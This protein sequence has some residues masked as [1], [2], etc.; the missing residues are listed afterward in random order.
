MSTNLGLPYVEAHNY[1]QCGANS[2]QI[3]NQ[4]TGFAPP[5][6]PNLSLYCLWADGPDAD[7]QTLMRASTNQAL[8]DQM[9]NASVLNNSNALNRL[10]AKGAREILVE[11]GTEWPANAPWT[12][13]LMGTNSVAVSN[14]NNYV[15]RADQA[16]IGVMN[17]YGRARPDLR[18]QSLDV[19]ARV[20]EIMADPAPYGFTETSLDALYDPSLRNKSFTGPGA[21]YMFWGWHPTTKLHRLIAAWHE[22]MLTNS[23]LETV[24]AHVASGSP[25]VQ[26]DH[27]RVGRDYALQ[28]ST[29]LRAWS[30]VQS[31][32]ASAGTNQWAGSFDN[33]GTQFYRLKWQP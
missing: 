4:V 31:F 17:A 25:V 13:G 15:T 20:I 3:L 1:A 6:K 21:D 30:D 16:F 11:I 22:E 19:M 7:I 5:A 27:L 12:L 8:G 23:V 28:S 10:Y 24:E 32:T 2:A 29:D 33:A 18:I 26:M 9:L 14:Y